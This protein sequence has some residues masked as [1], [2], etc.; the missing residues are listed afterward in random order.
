MYCACA[1]NIE[2]SCISATGDTREVNAHAA[3]CCYVIVIPSV[4]MC[5]CVCVCVNEAGGWQA[6]A[7]RGWM[8]NA[9]GRVAAV[10]TSFLGER[11]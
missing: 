3:V 4:C 1:I 2:Y 11:G 6:Q 9:S 8:E 7:A 5:V 10:P